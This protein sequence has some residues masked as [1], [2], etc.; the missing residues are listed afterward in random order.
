[1]V[2]ADFFLS[3]GE[4]LGVLVVGGDEGIGVLLQLLDGGER[5]SAERL[6][7][8]DGEPGFDLIEL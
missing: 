3:R 2:L 4:G 1:V 5:G 6:S 8:K 7:L